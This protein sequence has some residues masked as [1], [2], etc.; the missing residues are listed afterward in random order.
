[1]SFE[2]EKNVPPPVGYNR[3]PRSAYPFDKLE[4]GDSFVVGLD[5]RRSWCFIFSA[6]QE[7]QL[8]HQIKIA[9][10]LLEDGNRRVWRVS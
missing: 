3:R 10:R 4:V 2:I 5:G 1:M 9:T 8:K 6:I 7:A